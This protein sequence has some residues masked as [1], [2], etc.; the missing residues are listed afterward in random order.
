VPAPVLAPAAVPPKKTTAAASSRQTIGAWN[1]LPMCRGP[2][3]L[4]DSPV[5]RTSAPTMPQNA[6]QAP[7]MIRSHDVGRPLR[8]SSSSWA[9]R[10]S[11]LPRDPACGLGRAIGAGQVNDPINPARRPAAAAAAADRYATVPGPLG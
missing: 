11:E 8:A 9:S 10:N 3:E 5:R 6:T 4:A 2:P 7:M 1:E